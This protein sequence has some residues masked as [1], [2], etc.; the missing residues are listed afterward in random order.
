MT[1]R[2]DIQ[3]IDLTGGLYKVSWKYKETKV[4]M[5]VDD[6]SIGKSIINVIYEAR[7]SLDAY[8]HI[9]SNFF[10]SL[11]PL[12]PKRSAPEVA[13]LMADAAYK[14]LTRYGATTYRR[15]SSRP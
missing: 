12:D 11:F 14:A 5:K 10:T 4:K 9:H 13:S 8:T 7:K 6:I 2:K 3:I 1:R 15:L